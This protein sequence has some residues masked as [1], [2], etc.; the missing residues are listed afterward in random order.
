MSWRASLAFTLGVTAC[1]AAAAFAHAQGRPVAEQGRT[2]DCSLQFR[3]VLVRG[4]STTHFES[5]PAS[6]GRHNYYAG[7]GVD[8]FCT[9]TDQRVRS[10]SAEQ[11]EDHRLLVLIG[12]VHYSEARVDLYADRVTYYMGEERVVAQGHVIGRTG[13]GT[14]FQGPAAVYL[15]A[16]PGLRTQSRLDAGGRPD[17]WI[18]GRDAGTDAAKPDSTHVLADSIISLND[19][20]VYAIGN[21]D[22]YRSDM[23]AHGDSAMMD[24]GREFAAL[25][26]SPIVRGTGNTTFTLEGRAIDVFSRDRKAERIRSS[27]DAKAV[28]KDATMTAD[29]IDLR[30]ANQQLVRVIAWG[31]R[32]ARALQPDR[33]I[34]ADSIDVAMPGQSL[35]AIDAIGTAR[36]ETV[37]DSLKVRSTSRDWF[38]GDTIRA[39]FDSATAGDSARAAIRRLVAVGHARSWQQSARDGVALPDSQPAINYVTGEQIQADFNDER[40]LDRVRVTGQVVGVTVQP[41]ADTTKR[42]TPPKRPPPGRRR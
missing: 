30:L 18:S 1:A 24:E 36:A 41:A 42:P 37:P 14:H 4:Q 5:Q 20:L 23:V 10:D 27:G 15:R 9:N 3:P 34:V 38:A 32:R 7:G 22:I 17:S 39:S 29:S 16:K 31:T 19:S 6:P 8:A 12:R 21:V 13:S 11:Y 25:R 33:E 2:E 40:A 28:N 26:K 35:R